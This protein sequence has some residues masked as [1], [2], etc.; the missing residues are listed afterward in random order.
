MKV[1]ISRINERS[2]SG[3]L[4]FNLFENYEVNCLTQEWDITI[5]ESYPTNLGI[6]D[7]VINCTGITLN[8]SVEEFSM[9]DSMK[10][11]ET[12]VI[13]AML[14]TSMYTQDR[15]STGK[16]G[17][18]IHI[19]SVGARKV[20]TNCSAYCASK[21]A[22]A[23]YIMCAAYELKGKINVIGVHPGGN[24]IGTKMTQNVQN[25]LITQ[26][27]MTKEQVEKIYADGQSPCSIASFIEALINCNLEDMSGENFYLGKS[28]KAN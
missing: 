4:Y 9:Y 14:F 5:P 25:E 19:G 12:N 27:G 11:F 3:Y 28:W 10:I 21:A 26:R 7:V 24:L 13:G 23:H 22:L 16:Q 1:L 6:Y 20:F 18:I 2:L 8:Q 15:I 17:A